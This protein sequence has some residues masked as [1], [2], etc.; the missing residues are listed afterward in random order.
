MIGGENFD[1]RA[2]IVD[3]DTAEI[4]AQLVAALVELGELAPGTTTM[5]QRS[6]GQIEGDARVRRPTG[7]V[8][9]IPQVAPNRKARRAAVARERI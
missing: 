5:N 1:E 2:S 9:K 8:D 7:Q 6:A 4:E 3:G